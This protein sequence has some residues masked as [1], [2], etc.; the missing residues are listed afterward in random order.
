[1]SSPERPSGKVGRLCPKVLASMT[2]STGESTLSSPCSGKL[3]GAGIS[4][5]RADTPS[6]GSAA[7]LYSAMRLPLPE[8]ARREGIA[9]VMCSTW[10]LTL[11]ADTA[12]TTPSSDI[13]FPRHPARQLRFVGNLSP[14]PRHLAANLRACHER[15]GP[16]SSSENRNGAR[17]GPLWQRRLR[18]DHAR[19]RARRPRRHPERDGG[20]HRAHGHVALHPRKERLLC[21]PL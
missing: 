16:P 4:C 6:L 11:A 2:S 5:T 12:L 14:Q 19:D 15:G 1:M 9:V 13:R 20:R 7:A 18:A 10:A 3:T 21:R 8:P 17:S